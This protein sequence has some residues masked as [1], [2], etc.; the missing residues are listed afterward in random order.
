MSQTAVAMAY[1]DG[2]GVAQNYDLAVY[3]AEKTA[4]KGEAPAQFILGA[5]YA[6]GW[7]VTK[8]L[9]TSVKWLEKS[10]AQ[11]FE[12]A[13]K[14][15]PHLRE[16]LRIE[17]ADEQSRIK[18]EKEEEEYKEAIAGTTTEFFTI[19]A[20]ALFLTGAYFLEKTYGHAIVLQLLAVAATVVGGTCVGMF[21]FGFWAPLS[22][23]GFMAGLGGSLYI[24][25]H[26]TDVAL[27]HKGMNVAV[28]MI[29]LSLI[30][31]VIKKLIK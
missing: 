17:Q 9:G 4:D 26:Q 24:A 30:R 18:R 11:G 8:D 31:I 22:F 23:L 1:Y 10:A 14:V 28:V 13:V 2:N 5:C 3:W 16:K 7:S 25:F 27:A 20:A 19:L 15:L 29:G 21:F 6:N 12:P